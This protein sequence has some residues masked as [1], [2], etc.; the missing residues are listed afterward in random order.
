MQKNRRLTQI[1]VLLVFLAIIIFINL[2]FLRLNILVDL[3]ENEL[4]SISDE[5]RSITGAVDRDMDVFCFVEDENKANVISEFT[6]NFCKTSEKLSYSAVNPIEHPELTKRYTDGGSEITNNTVVFDNGKNY[7][8]IPYEE[9]LSYNYLTGQNNLLVAEERF[10][11]AVMSLN[12]DTAAKIAY[13]TGHGE[14]FDESL[15][16]R[17]GEIG[18]ECENID[19]R[20]GV[21]SGFDV[22][23]LISPKTDYTVQE[24][25][26]LDIFLRDGGTVIMALD[27][28]IPQLE[29]LEGF[30]SEW[31]VAVGRNMVFSTDAKNIMGNQPYSVIGRLKPH[32]VTDGLIKNNISPVFFASRAITPLWEVQNGIS[33]TVLSESAENAR[34]VSIDT[35]QEEGSGVFSLLTLS[36]GAKGRIFTFGSNMF[37]SDDLKAYNQDLIGNIITWST[38]GELMNEVSPKLVASSNIQVPKSDI[39]LWVVIFGIIIPVFIAA[40]GILMAIRR[41]RL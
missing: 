31:G 38:D 2:I 33:V 7:K 17:I 35:Q 21:L 23:L 11:R 8:I 15:R 30:L 34:A 19:I 14:A 1:A 27:A 26:K 6:R 36:Q 5:A 24:L 20:N 9:M 41:R 13:L 12:K 18:T 16:K 4:Y 32:P 37:F 39:E 22:A 29:M 3:T 25:E 28:S 10:C 40:A